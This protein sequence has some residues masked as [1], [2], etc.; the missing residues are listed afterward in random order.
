MVIHIETWIYMLTREKGGRFRLWHHVTPADGGYGT[1][2]DIYLP[3]DYFQTHSVKTFY[4][5][6]TTKHCRPDPKY[7]DKSAQLKELTKQLQAAGWLD[8]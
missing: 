5:F 2:V 3:A 8:R 7:V 1:E 4:E 6:V